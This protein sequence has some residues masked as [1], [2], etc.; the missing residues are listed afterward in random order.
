MSDISEL[1]NF[2]ETSVAAEVVEQPAEAKQEAA[3]AETSATTQATDKG[4]LDAATPAAEK[5]STANTS[6]D[7]SK[8]AYLDEKRKRQALEQELEELKKPKT[9]EKQ[10]DA[11]DMFVDPAAYTK[12]QDEKTKMLILRNKAE[13]SADLMRDAKPDYDEKAARFIDMAK[14]DQSLA[15]KMYASP[16]PAK[17]A[18]E[19]A[20]KQ[21][22]LDAIGDPVAYEAKLREKILAELNGEKPAA[23]EIP[24]KKTIE[25]TP[26]LATASA[27]RSN[28]TTTS[29]ALEELFER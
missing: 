26:S 15:D 9:P 4:E 29:V 22:A 13:M 6:T 21:M 1:D 11:P 2:L 28:N 18:Y 8:T 23:E 25:K 19:T 17:F 7:W 10:D 5:D 16:N 24:A 14:A 12:H 3:T 20:A 27:A